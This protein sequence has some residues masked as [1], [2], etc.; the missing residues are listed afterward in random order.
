[1]YSALLGDRRS[2]LADQYRLHYVGTWADDDN[3]DDSVQF[4]VIAAAG[5][6]MLLSMAADQASAQK[7]DTTVL[8]LDPGYALS[9]EPFADSKT[10]AAVL[11]FRLRERL[12]LGVQQTVNYAGIA[13]AEQIWDSEEIWRGRTAAFANFDWNDRDRDFVPFIGAFA[14]LDYDADNASVFMGPHA[15]FSQYL[16]GQTFV[17]LKYRYEWRVDDLE[18][19]D[20]AGTADEGQH[21]VSIGLGVNF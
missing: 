17:R 6:G 19:H 1:M 18:Q 21:I 16:D 13:D 7:D 9:E 3:M 5:C 15:G 2:W 12:E 11:G 4:K 14:G 20:I 10:H 8:M